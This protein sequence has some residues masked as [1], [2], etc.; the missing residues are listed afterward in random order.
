VK[1]CYLLILSLDSSQTIPVG[2]R[3]PVHFAAGCYAYVGSALSGL[4][5]RVAR[6]MRDNKRLH[7]HIDYLLVMARLERVIWAQV[8]RKV[9]CQ[10]ARFMAS[11]FSS[12][13]D[14]GASDCRCPSHLFWS[15]QRAGLARAARTAIS[16][17]GATPVVTT[18][19][20]KKSLT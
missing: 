4:E 14:F 16:A 12:I 19:P 2:R 15:R 8:S 13:P 10:L 18:Y 1:G 9:E 5:A 6:H 3:G 17:C 11:H 20:L 7:W